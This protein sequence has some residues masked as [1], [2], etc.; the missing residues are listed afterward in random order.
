[1][2]QKTDLTGEL[3]TESQNHPVEVCFCS[4]GRFRFV[5]ID[6]RYDAYLDAIDGPL[7]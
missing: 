2:Q 6:V 1:M 3:C 4:D 5:F 7:V